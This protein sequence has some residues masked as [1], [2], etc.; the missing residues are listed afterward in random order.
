MNKIFIFKSTCVKRNSNHNSIAF[1]YYF[2]YFTGVIRLIYH[3]LYCKKVISLVN[4]T[5]KI[6][7]IFPNIMLNSLNVLEN[8]LPEEYIKI[9]IFEQ[10]IS[11][12]KIRYKKLIANCLI[13]IVI[14]ISINLISVK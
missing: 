9:I 6:Y 2:I 10:I 14:V 8:I 11:T 4:V 3:S 13:I 7:E 1:L 5:S 12:Y